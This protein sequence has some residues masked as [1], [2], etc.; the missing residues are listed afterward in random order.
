MDEK[1]RDIIKQQY[2]RSTDHIFILREAFKES[3][4]TDDEAFELTSSYVRQSIFDSIM[5]DNNRRSKSSYAEI[6]KAF[7]KENNDDQT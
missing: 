2:K 4:F 3:G 5:R 6:R 7:K 1:A